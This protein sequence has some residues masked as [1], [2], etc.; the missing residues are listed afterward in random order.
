MPNNWAL[1]DY[2]YENDTGCY[3]R[4]KHDAIEHLMMQTV[5]DDD[6]RTVSTRSRQVIL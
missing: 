6:I 3:K 4:E 1:Y 5:K 2:L